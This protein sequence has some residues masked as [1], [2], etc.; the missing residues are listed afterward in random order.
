M[1]DRISKKLG[2]NDPCWCD[3]GKKYKKCHR[4][5]ELA[6]SVP[7]EA[8]AGVLRKE[9][10]HKR[11]LHPR[12]AIDACNKIVSAH[13]IQR[14]SVLG[15]LVDRT[16][17]V[18]SFYRP[19]LDE[20]KGGLRLH[21]I[22]WREASTF[23]GFCSKH[24]N[25]VFKPLEK[26]AFT[27]SPEQCFLIGYRALCHEI[28]Q[29]TGL[30]KA[31]PILR[32]LVDRGV[33]PEV[34]RE[35]QEMWTALE[36]GTRSGLED[37]EKLKGVM[38]EQLLSGMYSGWS[39]AVVNFRG[40]LCVASTGA[41]SPNRDFENQQLQVLHDREAEMQELPFGIVATPEGG[42]A[43]FLWKSGQ[44]APEAF[45]DSL[46]RKGNERLPSLIV[47]FMFAYIENTY[48]SDEWWWS[49]PQIHRDHLESLA[50][51]SN[52]YYAD[53]NYSYWRF[54]PW[55]VLSVVRDSF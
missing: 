1:I 8:L 41:V 27:G 22:G 43:V 26:S 5:R 18:R 42:A 30:L 19:E 6:A 36:A 48:F 40:E 9:S 39:R 44:A 52:A 32:S 21:R 3:S 53:F 15:R 29:K 11:C 31:D 4:D 23:T 17:H 35:I 12:T 20:T 16:N 38:D 55:E 50:A 54:V 46:L 37:F 2:P 14:S 34:Q 49:M 24:D 25:L 28:Y 10:T 51:I 13:T 7:F 33:P 45:V 47:Q